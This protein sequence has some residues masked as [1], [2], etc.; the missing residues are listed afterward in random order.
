MGK[1]VS[2]SL[3]LLLLA[4]LTFGLWN[5]PPVAVVQAQGCPVTPYP[6][7]TAQ[8]SYSDKVLGTQSG[9]LLAYWKLN[10]TSGTV[11]ADSSGN[12]RD[13][14]YSGATL[15]ATTFLDGAPAPSFDEI[16]DYLNAYSALQPVFN[17]QA[18]TI[19]LWFR[20]SSS[21]VWTDGL[22]GKLANFVVD[23]NASLYMLKSAASDTLEARYVAGGVVKPDRLDRDDDQLAGL[24]NHVRLRRR[25]L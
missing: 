22:N 19:L 9:H 11:A 21:G 15:N 17:G 8:T 2:A 18:G 13:A 1:I 23:A 20:V 12:G 5:A 24:R 4:G 25:R 7:P 16:N 14:S 6:S 3:L 10:E